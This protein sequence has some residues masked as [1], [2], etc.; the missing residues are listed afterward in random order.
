MLNWV[1]V[2][3]HPFVSPPMPPSFYVL[4]CLSVNATISYVVLL[5]LHQCHHP[6]MSICLST[7]AS[8]LLCP[9]V[10]PPMP[11]SFYVLFCLSVNATISYVVLLSLHQCHHPSMSICLSTNASIPL[12]PFV[13]PPMPP[14]FYVLFCLSV[15]STLPCA[16]LLSLHC[17]RPPVPRC[18]LYP[19]TDGSLMIIPPAWGWNEA[20]REC[21]RLT[22][23]HSHAKLQWRTR[24]IDKYLRTPQ[25]SE[26]SIWTMKRRY[27]L[28]KLAKSRRSRDNYHLCPWLTLY[29]LNVSVH[30]L[31]I[32]TASQVPGCDQKSEYSIN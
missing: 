19:N 17:H 31:T 4:F 8:I 14:S 3:C 22:A 23:N 5:S 9:F 11:P 2:L 15:N 27:N 20:H 21:F 26:Q 13:S 32:D 12:C 30:A 16:L 10:S 18:S 7:N 25:A 6:S 1:F 24:V 28:L 29:S